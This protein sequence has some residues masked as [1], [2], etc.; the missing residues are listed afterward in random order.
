MPESSGGSLMALKFELAMA[1]G[2]S[3][4]LVPMVRRFIVPLLQAVKG[5]SCQVWLLPPDEEGGA[6]IRVAYPQRSLVM[7]DQNPALCAWV[8]G[9]LASPGILQ[10][11][12]RSEKGTC[13]HALPVGEEGLLVIEHALEPIA[14]PVLDAVLVLLLRLARACRACHEHARA[15]RLLELKERAE[16]ERLE[17]TQRMQEVFALSSDAFVYFDADGRIG[18]CNPAV[19]ALLGQPQSLLLGLTAGQLDALLAGAVGEG[20]AAPNFAEQLR[21]V[22]G[23]AGAGD[24]EAQ[25]LRGQLHLVRPQVRV[26]SWSL[27]RT[28]ANGRAVLYLRDVTRETEVDRMKSEFLTTAAHE[29]RTPMVSVFGF[30]ELLLNRPV[31]EERRRDMLTTIH[32]QSSLLINM[33]N[34]LLDLARIEARQGKDL[35]R[36]SC[37]LGTLIEQAAA[38]FAEQHGDSRLRVAAWHGEAQLWVDPEKT[39]R[40]FTNVLSNAFKYSPEGGEIELTTVSGQLRGLPAVGVRITDHGIGMS[41]EQLRRVFERFYRADPSGNIPGTGLGMSLVKEIAELQG[42]QVELQSEPGHGTTVTVWFPLPG[43]RPAAL[44]PEVLQGFAAGG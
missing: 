43:A 8:E 34:E 18:L 33:V 40:L 14:R 35:K 9:C 27:R 4:D 39:H 7:W 23:H 36:E 17:A 25:V 5:L 12:H 24:D 41:P 37:R 42:G 30:T 6:P 2:E 3:L 1:I 10:A 21:A 13:L 44:G 15:R 19:N 11:V 29:L 28:E 32:R 20:Q 31:G 26:V 16:Q 22:A 38:P